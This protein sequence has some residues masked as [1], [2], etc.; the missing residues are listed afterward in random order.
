MKKQH[1]DI[2]IGVDQLTNHPE[3]Q[4]LNKEEFNELP[5]VDTLSEEQNLQSETSR[6]DF[7]KYLGFGL[8]AA[9]LAAGCEIPVKRAIPYVIKP[10]QIVPGVATYYAST[11]VQGGDYCPVLVKTREGRPIKVEGNSLSSITGGGTSARAQ[12]SVLSLY[13]TSRIPGPFKI[14]DGKLSGA[15]KRSR[16]MEW[17][18][19]DEEI[20][21]KL[22]ANSRVRIVTNTNMSPSA[23]AAMDAFKLAYPNTEVVTYDPVSSSAI[24]QANEE[25]FGQAVI[26][27]YKFEDAQVIVSFDADFLGTWISPIEYAAKYIQNRKIKDVEN[28]S[29]SYHVQVES[30]MSL[31]GSNSDNRILVKP[32][33]QGAAIVALYN[34]VAAL[35]GGASVSGPKLNATQAAKFKKLAQRLVDNKQKSLVVSGSNNV[36]EQ[37]LINGINAMLDNYSHTIDFTHASM[38]RQGMDKPVQDLIADMKGGRVDALFVMDG[39]NPAWDLP[40]AADFAAGMVKVGLKVSFSGL[41]SE[42]T[43]LCDYVTPTNHFLESWGDVEAKKGHFSLIQ[44][45]ISPLFNTRQAELTLLMWAKD[46]T[47]NTESDQP[48]FEYLKSTWETNIFPQQT[49]FATFQQ[50]WDSSLH[51]GV[52]EAAQEGGAIY[53]FAGDVN[54]AASKVRKPAAGDAMEISFFETVNMGAGQYANNPW[55]QEMPDPITRCVWGNYLAIPV[56]W[57]GSRRFQSLNNLNER[58]IYGEAD[59]VDLQ[60]GDISNTATTVRQFG[61]MENTVALAIGY[62]REMSGMTGQALGDKVGI[63]AYPMMSI[64][65]NGNTQYYAT[66]VSV[67]ESKGTEKEFACVQYHHSMGLKGVDP[68]SGEEIN[69]DEKAI[70]TLGEGYQG[71]I[72]NRS[73]IYQAN[74]SEVEELKEHIAEK[75]S[76]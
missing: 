18:A 28:P 57:D 34:E 5:V 72:T 37:V 31:T 3:Y 21:G 10:D 47:L 62:G 43:M 17:S 49:K 7:L 16:G 1:K 2:W 24:L 19:V 38:Q 50:F 69:V 36:G 58:E 66:T 48:Y 9:T 29:M 67:S 23:K 26:P 11:F 8:G 14:A 33:Q 25:S 73:I 4:K 53:E 52:F 40:N 64:D 56:S 76:E 70:M 30:H 44:P 27:D 20:G 35:T 45:T 59:M 32:S 41:P 74:L 71:G 15:T 63:N 39:A 61:Q 54:A 42:T 55:L 12:A 13:D 65:T 60:V 22:N 75:R 51:D 68:A 46:E 6:R